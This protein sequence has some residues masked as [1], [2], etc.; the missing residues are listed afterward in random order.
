MQASK[1]NAAGEWRGADPPRLKNHCI[2]ALLA[3]L[4]LGLT[5]VGVSAAKDEADAIPKIPEYKDWGGS[6]ED[7]KLFKE[8]MGRLLATERA[9]K[10]Y[11]SLYAWPPHVYILPD[12]KGR[13]NAFVSPYALDKMSGKLLV[14]A[15]ITEGFMTQIVKDDADILAAVMGH[16]LGHILKKHLTRRL[17]NNLDGPPPLLGRLYPGWRPGAAEGE[18]ANAWPNTISPF[19]APV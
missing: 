8:V 7:K 17:G 4:V 15:V 1:I 2:G 14:R 11:P 13:F 16:E 18:V 6:A 5:L 19:P 10:S 3:S 12:S 9:R